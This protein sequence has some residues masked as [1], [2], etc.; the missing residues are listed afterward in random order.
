MK[1]YVVLSSLLIVLVLSFLMSSCEDEEGEKNITPTCKIISPTN[2]DSILIG[3]IVEIVVDADDED[4]NLKEIL[5]YVNNEQIGADQD[6]PYSLEWNTSDKQVSNYT[7]KVEAIDELNA[8]AESSVIV[9]LLSNQLNANFTA[10]ET[11]IVLGDTVN[12]TDLTEGVISIWNWQMGD[13]SSSNVENPSHK[14]ATPGIYTVSLKVQND[15]SQ[16]TETKT[17]YITV[18]T[19]PTVST[20]NISQYTATTI[21]VGGNITNDGFSN[22]TDRGVYYGITDNPIEEGTKFQIDFENNLFSDTIINLNTNTTYYIKAYATNSVGT[23]YGN[24]VSV[25]TL[26]GLPVITTS[27][28][29]DITATSAIGGGNI[30]DDGGYPIVIRG[31]CWSKNPNP[32]KE[33]NYTTANTDEIGSF[34]CILNDLEPDVMYYVRAFTANG[35]HADITT[36][37]NEVS[38][39]TRDGIPT[40]LTT[41]AIT[42]ITTNSA[43]TG[44]S[45]D[46]DG[47]SAIISRGVCWNT[48]DNAS[49]ED[50][51]HTNDGSGTG[52]FTSN[53]T[54]LTP[55]TTYFVRSYATNSIGTFYGDYQ[56]FT[57]NSGLPSG[58]TTAEV[59]N[60]GPTSAVS[61]GSITDDGGYSVTERGICWSTSNNPTISNNHTNDGSG[62]GSFTSNLSGLDVNTTYYVRAYATNANG[63]VYGSE[64]SFTTLDG[65][66]SGVTTAEISN[67]GT[68]SAESGGSIIDD[69][70]YEVT[71]RGVCWST[72]NNPTISNNHTNDGSGIGTFT[73]NLTGL[74]VST[75]YYVRAYAT[76]E[77]GTVYGDEKSFTSETDITG[78]TGTLTDYD[79]NTYNWIGIGK[80]AWMAENLKVTHYPDGTAIPLITIHLDW[81]NLQDNNTDDAYCYYK[82]DIS[83]QYGALYTWA[84]AM[85]DNGVSSSDNPSGAQGVC[86]DGWHLPSDS[87]WQELLVYIADDGY[88]GQENIV[89]KSTSGWFDNQNGSDIYGFNALPGGIRYH[90]IYNGPDSTYSD[91]TFNATWWT[92]AESSSSNAYRRQITYNQADHITISYGA[93]KSYG[94]SIRCIK[95]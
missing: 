95:D 75:T 55:N 17:D 19:L 78:Q 16:D 71:S 29:S 68:T 10:D 3:E 25:T 48:N 20:N 14:Y 91:A 79:G 62:T 38:F 74:D 57:T 65:L 54:E 88:S 8:K 94:F 49:I 34:T 60:V 61:G 90:G 93:N 28:V 82:N 51:S 80:Q 41:A 86:P 22:I 15:F 26:E 1:K 85:G 77:N 47:G 58:I 7:I 30:T 39:T 52:S 50:N 24:T 2:N 9:S 81:A 70:G 12:F 87:E 92:S 36:Y 4:G 73:S 59:S 76:N 89:L 44:G 37:G 84:A 5:F 83:T 32:T 69:G 35:L 66:P 31:V 11:T 64:K 53:L 6:Y 72:S 46:D 43:V 21:V 67:I 13:G 33:D 23:Q 45:I 40:G 63:T 18:Q 56:S 27:E 42:E